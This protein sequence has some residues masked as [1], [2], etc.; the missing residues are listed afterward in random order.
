LA[1]AILHA[2]DAIRSRAGH[3][4]HGGVAGGGDDPAARW[5]LLLHQVP[6]SR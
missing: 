4:R 2:I 5:H 1:L 6:I 3:Q